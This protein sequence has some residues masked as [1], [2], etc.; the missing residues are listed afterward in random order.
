MGIVRYQAITHAERQ[1][2]DWARQHRDDLEHPVHISPAMSPA[3]LVALA[4]DKDRMAEL[5]VED[6][7]ALNDQWRRTFGQPLFPT[8]DRLMA[9]W[10]GATNNE[11]STEFVTPEPLPADD[12]MLDAKE[13]CR[14]IG[15]HKATLWR[16]VERGDFPA[17]HRPTERI[18]VWPARCVRE[19][20]EKHG[21]RSVPPRARR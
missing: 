6:L 3:D 16:M 5:T 19:W 11:S 14:R 2:E 8:F 1:V 7:D 21:P 20:L 4:R 10:S 18:R 9:A 12:T 13:V 15:V 17:P